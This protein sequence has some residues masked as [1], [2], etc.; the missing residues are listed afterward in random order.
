M[1]VAAL[2]TGKIWHQETILKPLSEDD[3]A[4]I[5]ETLLKNIYKAFHLHNEED[6]YDKLALT[7]DGALLEQVY[8]QQRQAFAIQNAGGAQAKVNRVKLLENDFQTDSATSKTLIYHARWTAE[9]AVSHW[10]HTH[11]RTNLYEA[12]VTL[13][14]DEGKWKI[15]GLKILDE[16]RLQQ[17]MDNI[18]VPLP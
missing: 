8:L 9:G 3:A 13:F 4:L 1:M 11:K 5:L 15:S 12:L 6:V 16:K 17:G 7:V 2:L 18:S 10:G 14:A